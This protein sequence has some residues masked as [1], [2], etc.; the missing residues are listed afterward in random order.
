MWGE[1]GEI[2]VSEIGCLLSEEGDCV[3][4]YVGRAIIL[5]ELVTFF[6][7]ED[8]VVFFGISFWGGER[9]GEKRRSKVESKIEM[10]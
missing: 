3:F 8:W 2:S 10:K 4:F 5:E 9:D 6:F 1:M 7:K